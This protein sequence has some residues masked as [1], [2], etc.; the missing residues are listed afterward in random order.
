MDVSPAQSQ[1][2]FTL[3]ELLAVIVI[4]GILALMVTLQWPTGINLGGQARQLAN[5]IRYTQG[6]A[7][8]K[9]QR[10]YLI[11]QSAT[12]YQI[13]NAAGTPIL[14]PTGSTTMTLNS[15]ITFGTFTNLP[16]N[17]IAF[18]SRGTPYTTSTSPGT[19]LAATA[20]MTL[21]SGSA[22]SSVTISPQTGQV[23]VP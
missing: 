13:L 15:G 6:L 14:L 22:S 2:G 10:Y 21:V 17:L 4:A 3:I 19:A 23:S 20:T 16:N 7:M 8:T 12:T 11:K 18:D 9:G 5:D 1:S